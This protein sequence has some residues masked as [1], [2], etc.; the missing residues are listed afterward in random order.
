MENPKSF[1]CVCGNVYLYQPGLYR[2]RKNCD[3][4]NK[5]KNSESD[6]NKTKTFNCVC[7]NAYL[8]KQGLY[9]HRKTCDK[10]NNKQENPLELLQR[11][12][13]LLKCNNTELIE[14]IN[15]LQSENYVLKERNNCMQKVLEQEQNLFVKQL[16]IS[17]CN[18]ICAAVATNY[19]YLLQ[20]REFM[21]T[22]EII[23]KVGMTTKENHKRFNQYPKG[24]ILIYQS[25]CVNCRDVEKRVISI[26]KDIFKQRTDIG[27]EYFEG[28]YKQMI[29]IIHRVIQNDC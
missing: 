8:Q 6:I 2:H 28:D 10:Y 19:V 17:E 24:S 20:E 29:N 14:Q 4:Y 16:N 18:K 21:K 11:Q 1:T 23:Y 5:Q 12:I 3:K 9:R 27:T 22:N 25:L 26:F 13:E 7:G 15:T